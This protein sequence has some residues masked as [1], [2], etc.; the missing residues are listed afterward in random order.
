MDAGLF[1]AR[2][3]CQHPLLRVMTWW[4]QDDNSVHHL[5]HEVGVN[6]WC[7]GARRAVV[8]LQCDWIVAWTFHRGENMLVSTA[9]R[10]RIVVR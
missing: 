10:L 5:A 6:R 2:D 4:L 1:V 7:N 8:M 9:S 3:A